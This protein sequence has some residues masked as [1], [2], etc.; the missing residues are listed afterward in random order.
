M[1]RYLVY[2]L[3][4]FEFAS[5]IIKNI[6]DIKNEDFK[7][8]RKTQDAILY[9]IAVLGEAVKKLSPEFRKQHPSIPWKQIAGMRDKLI[10]E[11]RRLNIDMVWQVT[12][13]NIP[14]LLNYIKPLLP[15]QRE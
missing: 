14:E 1:N 5:A 11:Y 15:Q 2:L 9:E 10:H 6:K 4:I 8:D 12:Q 7:Q 13:T 3:D